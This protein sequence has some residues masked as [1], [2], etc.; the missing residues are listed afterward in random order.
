MDNEPNMTGCVRTADMW[1]GCHV[2]VK[3]ETGIMLA[4]SR[5]VQDP[6]AREVVWMSSL[7]EP[8]VGTNQTDTLRLDIFP[9]EME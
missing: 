1:G 8:S 4:K 3:A 2:T 6:A 9:S 7:L 5:N